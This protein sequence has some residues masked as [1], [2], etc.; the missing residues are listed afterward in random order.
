M[1][2]SRLFRVAILLVALFPA[3]LAAQDSEPCK[4]SEASAGEPFVVRGRLSLSN[5]NPSVRIWI[6]GTKRILGVRGDEKP[7]LPTPLPKMLKWDVDIF[8]DFTVCPMTKY[9]PG[10][11]QM[12][13]I[14]SADNLVV[15]KR[16]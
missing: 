15:K 13:C 10:H 11:M 6:V 12:V 9:R 2:S 14:K 4:R 3:Y 7:D 1:S 5:G 16:R 8:G